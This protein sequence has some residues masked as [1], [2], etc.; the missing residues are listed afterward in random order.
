MKFSNENDADKLREALFYRDEFLSI[1]SHEL[2]TPLTSLKLHSQM[3][4]RGVKRNDPDAY[5][6]E[7]IDRLID[8]VEGHVNRLNS[9]IE[10]MLDISRIRTGR[11]LIQ[12]ESFNVNELIIELVQEMQSKFA[13]SDQVT[14]EFSSVVN[15]HGDRFR[16]KQVLLNILNNALK[17]G[18]GRH[19][20]IKLTKVDDFIEVAVKDQGIGISEV[21]QSRIFEKFERAIPASEVSGLG[22]GL[23]ISKQ[24][25][26]AHGGLIKLE[27]SI[28]V[29]STFTVV[30]PMSKL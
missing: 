5:S 8:Q 7:K 6:K 12:K 16:I 27:S 13:T 14:V 30:L 26:E 23:F 11:L 17:Y 20:K 18:R 1:A 4:K 15:F 29:G 10:D 28:N 24:I 19:I 9:L 2:K 21:E 22:L 25:V 3:F